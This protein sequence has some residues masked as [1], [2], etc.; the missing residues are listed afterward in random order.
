MR[1]GELDD[2]VDETVARRRHSLADDLLSD[3]IRAEDD[4]DRLN[5]AELRMLALLAGTDT[6]RNQVASSTTRPGP[7]TDNS[8]QRSHRSRRRNGTDDQ[9]SDSS[10]SRVVV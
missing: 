8:P 2:Y 10:A 1:V 7:H 4:G 3:L 9:P 5:T 6:T